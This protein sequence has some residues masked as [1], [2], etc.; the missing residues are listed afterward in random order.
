MIK[1]FVELRTWLFAHQRRLRAGDKLPSITEI[2]DRAGCHRDTIYS[3]LEGNRIEGHIQHALSIV[4]D[5]IEQETKDVRKT[6]LMN[7]QISSAG[8]VL[9]FGMAAKPLFVS[10][11]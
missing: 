5:R 4:I 1:T 9:G 10:R 3:L 6:H 11:R 2:A 8:P 7:I